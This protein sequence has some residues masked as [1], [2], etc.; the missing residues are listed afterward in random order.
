M[1]YRRDQG[2]TA[3]SFRQR[4][5]NVWLG[6]GREVPEFR[7]RGRRV[8]TPVATASEWAEELD[9]MASR[10]EVAPRGL[11]DAEPPTAFEDIIGEMFPQEFPEWAPRPA[12]RLRAPKIARAPR[13]LRPIKVPHILNRDDGSGMVEF[14]VRVD[15][16]GRG[17][18]IG[19]PGYGNESLKTP[20][21][22]DYD[23]VVAR[24]IPDRR[25]RVYIKDITYSGAGNPED[26]L[27]KESYFD[28]KG[29]LQ[30][31]P[32]VPHQLNP[33]MDLTWGTR[34]KYPWMLREPALNVSDGHGRPPSHDDYE[35]DYAWEHLP[36]VDEKDSRPNVVRQQYGRSWT[37]G[38]FEWLVDD[39]VI[40]QHPRPYLIGRLVSLVPIGAEGIAWLNMRAGDVNCVAAAIMSN[41]A[42]TKSLTA[43]RKKIIEEWAGIEGA[44]AGIIA[45]RDST[46]TDDMLEAY[47]NPNNAPSK[48]KLNKIQEEG[49][50]FKDTDELASKLKMRLQFFDVAGTLLHEKTG[51]NGPAYAKKHKTIALYRSD[52]HCSGGSPEFEM[53]TSIVVTSGP[54]VKFGRSGETRSQAKQRE[55]ENC[56]SK[57]RYII[58]TIRKYKLERA[59]IIGY[60]IV[61]NGVLYRPQGLD[62]QMHAAAVKLGL[63]PPQYDS[64]MEYAWAEVPISA[65]EAKDWP[66]YREPDKYRVELDMHIGGVQALHLKHWLKKNEIKSLF[67]ASREGWRHA[68][69]EA[70]AWTAE[71]E[72]RDTAAALYDMR[73]A[74][75]ACDSR[76]EFAAGPAHEAAVRFG[77]PRGG[78]SRKCL[79]P[80][81]ESVSKLAGFIRYRSLT[82]AAHTP[83]AIAANIA[84]HFRDRHAPIAIPA[85][86]WLHEHGYVEDYSILEVEYTDRLNGLTFPNDRNLSV[87]L[88]GSCA[89]HSAMRT[90]YTADPA[91]CDH[92]MNLYC[93]HPQ[94]IAEGFLVSYPAG[95]EATSKMKDHSHIRTYVLA[96]QAISMWTAI[97]ALGDNL[98]GTSADSVLVRDPPAAEAVINMQS[99]CAI[100]WGEFRPKPMPTIHASGPIGA[101]ETL[102]WTS[103]AETDTVMAAPVCESLVRTMTAYIEP[104]GFGKTTRAIKEANSSGR[105]TLILVGINKAQIKIKNDLI[106]AG[107]DLDNFTVDTYQHF[108][109]LPEREEEWTSGRM[110]KAGLCRDIVIWDEFAMAG[111]VI[112]GLV[113]PWMKSVG[114]TTILCGDP[115]GQLQ[116]FGDPYSG[117]AVMGILEDLN[118]PIEKGDGIDWRA[119]D[120]PILQAAKQAAWCQDDETQR[121]ELLKIATS[122]TCKQ[123]VDLWEPGDVIIEAT[124]RIGKRLE[125]MVEK[126]QAEKYGPNGRVDV[127]FRPNPDK[128]ELR[129]QYCKKVDGV[130][131][132][133]RIPAPG[134]QFIPAAIGSIVATTRESADHMDT[135]LWK[136]A[137]RIT[138][139]SVQG[140]TVKR[141]HKIFICLENMPADW[142]RN[143]IYVAMSRAE[144]ASQLYAFKLSSAPTK[145]EN[146]EPAE[147][148]WADDVY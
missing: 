84:H 43:A 71:G 26:Q 96:Y 125:E 135:D 64:G 101:P 8:P 69:I 41:L 58:D 61:A 140:E 82:I 15:T 115:I 90:F 145:K 45:T 37:T 138:V 105:K 88:I 118:V 107:A 98:I 133:V 77:F 122:L 18:A 117:Y 36:L 99:G 144:V 92:F 11:A 4:I 50:R 40:G 10:G 131:G 106:E 89:Y 136:L 86:V 44:G 95:K 121:E 51:K 54:I 67:P 94:K 128:P 68:T 60:E 7:T 91:E 27:L 24:I 62:M 56:Q 31:R 28:E 148:D 143:A 52:G 85:A 74:Y 20:N 129:E 110:G 1:S 38:R 80:T 103:D 29:D 111:P 127:V 76:P 141:A 21:G 108:F 81:W 132:R 78:R 3:G 137:S 104:G 93:A 126:A 22:K 46:T 13:A 17:K 55:M 147:S 100:R 6:I 42:A 83:T 9:L 19:E 48:H 112:L 87:R 63:R 142:C 35:V 119:K 70:I 57:D 75:L 109:H 5:E 66:K 116:K 79:A 114:F 123:V 49:A 130:L 14:Y 53:P 30:T 2:E 120:C 124:N 33:E 65:A 16:V 73:A 102:S 146:Y 23:K 25:Y 47:F 97:E 32:V 139:H 134:F 59:Q 72:K 34:K 113:L 39:K 12:H